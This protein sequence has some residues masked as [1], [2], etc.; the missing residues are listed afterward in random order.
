[1]FPVKF[2]SSVKRSI[3][4]EGCIFI[5]VLIALN[6]IVTFL[7]T[8]TGNNRRWSCTVTPSF[9]IE[10]LYFGMQASLEERNAFGSLK[11]YYT[12]DEDGEL[13]GEF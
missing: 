1:M 13:V 2:Y 6:F 4:I 10:I 7:W 3:P 5:E 9:T 11:R 8:L 12:M